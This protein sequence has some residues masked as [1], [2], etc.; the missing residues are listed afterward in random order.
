MSHTAQQPGPASTGPPAPRQTLLGWGR[1]ERLG[2][3]GGPKVPLLWVRP[4]IPV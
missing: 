3:G 4:L 2:E 1:K